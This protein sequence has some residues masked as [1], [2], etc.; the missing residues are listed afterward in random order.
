MVGGTVLDIKETTKLFGYPAKNRRV[1]RLWCV[2]RH[3]DEAAVYVAPTH[4]IAIGD[5]IWWQGR[6]V[7]WTPKDRSQTDIKV[8]RV[9]YSF[10]PKGES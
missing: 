1:Y 8:E 2:D 5:S 7:F 3:G 4:E 10:S 9:G 6:T